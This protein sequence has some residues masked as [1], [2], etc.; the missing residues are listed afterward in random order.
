MQELHSR[1]FTFSWTLFGFTPGRPVMAF[2]YFLLIGCLSFAIPAQAQNCT[3]PVRG[4]NMDLKDSDILLQAFS[5]GTKVT[6]ICNIGYRSAGGSGVTTCTAGTWS[7]VTLTCQRKS[8][9]SAG[10]VTNGRIDYSMGNE[11]GDK[12]MITCNAGYILVGS[13]EITCGDQGWM[14]RLPFCEVVV[15][16]P[17]PLLVD[18][19]FSP[20][21]DEYEYREV[22]QYSCQKDFVLN[23]AKTITCSEDGS[24]KPDAPTCV[25]V[26]CPDPDI[27]NA[28]WVTGSRPPHGFKATVTYRCLSG[29]KMNG[30]PNLVCEIDSKWLPPPLTCEPVTCLPPPAVPNGEFSPNKDSYRY[31]E[32]I[33]Y[34][35]Q[36]GFTL[37]GS[38]R[39]SCSDDGTFKLAPPKCS[40][41]TIPSKPPVIT[42]TTT[43]TTTI[44]PGSNGNSIATGLGIAGGVGG[45]CLLFFGGRKLWKKMK[46]SGRGQPDKNS[47]NADEE[48]ALSVR[49]WTVQSTLQP[50][51]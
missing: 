25:K 40:R 41:E 50:T 48:V 23:G 7:P 11:F 43:T 36:K 19:T 38:N 17:P 34:S 29:F 26:E 21:K 44:A 49:R 24:F 13:Q 4:P 39:L 6:F 9:G 10:Q 3:A 27:K 2:G 14:G 42:A 28:E 45:F 18:G 30:Q 22:V 5:E 31:Q 1:K 15:C 16:D 51:Q 37:I 47:P 20:D 35:C 12:I 8:C 33:Q 46:G 32:D